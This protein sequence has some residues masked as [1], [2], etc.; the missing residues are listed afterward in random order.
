[1]SHYHHLNPYEREIILK[2]VV[3]GR[4]IRSIATQLGRPPSTIS[5]E[6]KRNQQGDGTY[7]SVQAEE[8]HATAKVMKNVVAKSTTVIPLMNELN[9]RPRKCLGW[10][11]PFEVFYNQALHL[12]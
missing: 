9:H 11:T 7:S 12:V 8:N 2:N 5:R 3:L 4:P 6:L 10:K 1:M